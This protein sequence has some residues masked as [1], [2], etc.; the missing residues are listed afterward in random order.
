MP[1]FNDD[2]DENGHED[3]ELDAQ[4]RAA[5]EPLLKAQNEEENDGLG[6]DAPIEDQVVVETISEEDGLGLIDDAKVKGAPKEDVQAKAEDAQPGVGGDDTA[7]AADGEDTQAAAKDDLPADLTSASTS[8]LLSGLD[9]ARR[10]EITRR[11]GQADSV[12]G[13]FKGREAEMK[14][15]GVDAA[16]A[17]K[18]M[19][20]LNAFAQQKPDEYLAWVAQQTGGDNPAQVL[21]NAAKHLGYKL[22]KD[23]SDDDDLEFMDE[24]TRAVYEENRQLKA[25]QQQAAQFGPDAPLRRAAEDARDRLTSFVNA[26]GP[27]G[28]PLRPLFKHLEGRIAGLAQEHLR[29]TGRPVTEEDLGRFYTTAEAELRAATGYQAAPAPTPA[30]QP[31]K[32]VAEQVKDKAAAA[33]KAQRASKSI[34]GTGQGATRQPALRADASLDETL[35]HFVGSHFSG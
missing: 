9:D 17:M 18:R 11:I 32:T 34:D 8:D 22:V 23:Q 33:Q 25:R 13:I 21:E 29:A 2:I 19:L 14:L 24:R 12:L 16:T 31:Q 15:H 6:L 7:P 10:G 28:Q 35:R 30:A 1:D 4:L 27:D 26:T 3:D 5:I 20:D